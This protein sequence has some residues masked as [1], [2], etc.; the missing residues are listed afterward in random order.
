MSGA[1][2]NPGTTPARLAVLGAGAW[3]TALARLLG[4]NGHDVALWARQP[5]HAAA[6]VRDGENARHLPGARLGPRVRPTG[7]LHAAAEGA[8]ALVL[9][10]PVRATDAL[11]ARLPRPVAVVSCAKGFV[12]GDLTRL[13]QRIDAAF[14]GV[15]V[16]ALSGPNLAA[17][18]GRDQPA[19]ATVASGDDRLAHAVQAWFTQPSFRVYRSRDLVG[20]EASGALKNVIA[21]AAGMSDALGLGDNTKAALVTRGLA[22]LVRLGTRLGG[23]PRT[24]YGLAGL[25]DLMA[26]C[27]SAGSRNHQAGERLARGATLAEV[28]A[29]GLTAEGLATV[30]HVDAFARRHGLDLPLTRQVHEV[31]YGGRPPADAL[32]GL[33]TRQPTEE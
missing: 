24:F 4:R 3:G 2:P 31:V 26:T 14:P 19:A 17:E 28:E 22:E 32:L 15:P 23:E 30:A 29:A 20:V 21:L 12:D 27:S 16:A 33:M 13:S 18:I 8:E 9:A 6:L 11:L 1:S 25:G 5:N 10:V 7:G